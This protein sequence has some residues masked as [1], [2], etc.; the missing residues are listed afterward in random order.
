MQGFNI[1]GFGLLTFG[2]CWHNNHHALPSSA[3][4]VHA[5]QMDPGWW[6]LQMLERAGLVRNLNQ[7]VDLV[8]R[9][10]LE[11]FKCGSDQ[12][13]PFDRCSPQPDI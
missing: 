6:V 2:E 9:P 12:T 1:R 11:V 5:R 4:L 3:R 13:R 7:P 8:E 10:E